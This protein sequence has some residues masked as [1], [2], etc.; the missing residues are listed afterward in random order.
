MPK[1]RKRTEETRPTVKTRDQLETAVIN[2]AMAYYTKPDIDGD[3][4]LLISLLSACGRL[5]ARRKAE[6][7]IAAEGT[8]PR[9]KSRQK[10]V[11]STDASSVDGTPA[12]P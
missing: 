4:R 11:N 5:D 8:K 1:K 7:A 6:A 12:Q 3:G 10:E 2:A 9:V